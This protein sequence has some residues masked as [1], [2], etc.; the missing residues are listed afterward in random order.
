M[1]TQRLGEGEGLVALCRVEGGG[2]AVHRRQHDGVYVT[3]CRQTIAAELRKE[4][5]LGNSSTED[6]ISN[7]LEV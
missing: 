6:N 7:V 2:E 4:S 5:V 3:Y 1:H